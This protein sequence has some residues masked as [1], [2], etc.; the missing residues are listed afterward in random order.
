MR[1]RQE[2][3]RVYYKFF[4]GLITLVRQKTLVCY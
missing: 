1:T 3:E 4:K 2:M